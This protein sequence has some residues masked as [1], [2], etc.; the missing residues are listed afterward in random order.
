MGILALIRVAMNFSFYFL[1]LIHL[2]L[3]PAGASTQAPELWWV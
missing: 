2:Q 3:D 1:L